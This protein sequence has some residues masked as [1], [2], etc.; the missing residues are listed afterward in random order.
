MMDLFSMA[1]IRG[2]DYSFY[3]NALRTI[4]GITS[5][6]IMETGLTHLNPKDML[7]VTAG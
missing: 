4:E 2:L 1:E 7:I 6:E 5:E 3:Q